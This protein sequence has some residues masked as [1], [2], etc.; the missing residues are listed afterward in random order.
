MLGGSSVAVGA[1]LAGTPDVVVAV[2]IVFGFAALDEPAVLVAG[3]V[4][5]EVDDEAHV[6]LL[7]AGEHGVEVGHGAELFHHLAVVAD[8]VA[9]VGVGRVE[10]RAEPDDVDAEV[11]QVVELGGDAGQVADAVAVRVL[12]GAGVDL[13]DDG[14]LPPFLGVAVGGGGRCA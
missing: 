11:L 5:D 12:E 13:V 14:L 4:D 10:V 3:V 2:G 6:A 8:V 7:D 1:G 9:V